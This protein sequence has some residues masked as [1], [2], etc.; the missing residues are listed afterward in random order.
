MVNPIT[1]DPFHRA[2]FCADNEVGKIF[3]ISSPRDIRL[4]VDVGPKLK[5]LYMCSSNNCIFL[6]TENRILKFDKN[7]GKELDSIRFR[8]RGS[9]ASIDDDTIFCINNPESSVE[10]IILNEPKRRSVRLKCNLRSPEL[11][12]FG[13]K[14]LYLYEKEIN[15]ITI[16]RYEEQELRS[17]KILNWHNV[18]VTLDISLGDKLLV[19]E[20][21]KISILNEYLETQDT[22]KTKNLIHASISYPYLWVSETERL[23]CL[24][25]PDM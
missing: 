18:V 7:T 16:F 11:L 23:K 17:M 13:N 14:K 6:V 9:I 21:N 5:S 2:V 15:R 10:K 8:N 4:F 19:G 22:I 1:A 20:T 3:W 25:L 24:E 12:A